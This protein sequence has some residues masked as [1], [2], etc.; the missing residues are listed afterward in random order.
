MV[1]Q[2]TIGEGDTHTHTHTSNSCWVHEVGCAGQEGP[3]E[4]DGEA[5]F[6]LGFGG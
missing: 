6:D 5:V 1:Q 2:L 4:L 3:G